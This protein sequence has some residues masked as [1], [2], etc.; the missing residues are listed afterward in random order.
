MQIARI[1][2]AGAIFALSLSLS[3]CAKKK[4]MTYMA[5]RGSI[6]AN[7]DAKRAGEPKKEKAA[8]PTDVIVLVAHDAQGKPVMVEVQQ[9]SGDEDIDQRAL[10]LV[11]QKMTFP[12]GQANTTLV[13]IPAKS[14]PKN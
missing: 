1:I 6:G 13:T 9:S 2:L 10:R 12:K 14:V 5:P 8:K 11:A 3:G 4:T 7:S